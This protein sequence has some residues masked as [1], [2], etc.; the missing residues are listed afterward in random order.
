MTAADVVVERI[1]QLAA[2]TEIVSDRVFQ[3]KLQQGVLFPAVLVRHISGPLDYHLRG[4][5]T[6]QRT[7]I[8]VDAYADETSGGD[9]L[10]TAQAL[11][12]AIEG[13]G[14]GSS[15]SGLGGWI[16]MAGGS[17]PLVRVSGVLRIDEGQGY[18]P[19]ELRLVRVWRD[20]MVHWAPVS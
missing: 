4:P 3:L 11:A 9:P 5:V 19:E 15:A 18:D 16:G 2:V 13:D 1:G 17:P 6:W 7:R 14:L 10:V 20:Y 8:Q 12:D